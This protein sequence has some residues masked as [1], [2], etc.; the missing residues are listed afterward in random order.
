MDTDCLSDHKEG[1]DVSVV[2]FVYLVFTYLPGDS[3]SA[4]QWRLLVI[5]KKA[6]VFV[7]V[8]V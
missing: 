6:R 2:E 1:Q 3:Y 8:F 5:I 4:G 7:V